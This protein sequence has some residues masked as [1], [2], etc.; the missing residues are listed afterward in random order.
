MNEKIRAS[1]QHKHDCDHLDRGAV[2]I[3]DALRPRG[4]T[5]GG[6]RCHGVI[7]CVEEAHSKQHIQ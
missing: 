2:I 6:K 7:N 4:K 5:A 3:S 1:Q